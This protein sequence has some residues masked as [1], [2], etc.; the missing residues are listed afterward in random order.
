MFDKQDI[1][2]LP[3]EPITRAA[4]GVSDGQSSE[5]GG[6]LLPVKLRTHVGKV[7]AHSTVEVDVTLWAMRA[8]VV[9]VGSVLTVQDTVSGV[10]CRL[11]RKKETKGLSQQ[12][13]IEPATGALASRAQLQ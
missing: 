1:V 12:T 9:D 2:L 7:A 8:G 11:V 4:D 5:H 3:P 13:W 6:L 10:T